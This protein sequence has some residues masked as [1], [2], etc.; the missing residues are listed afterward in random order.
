MCKKKG[1]EAQPR[2]PFFILCRGFYGY[3]DHHRFP[4]GRMVDIKRVIRLVLWFVVGLVIGGGCTLARAENTPVYQVGY[5]APP[6]RGSAPLGVTAMEAC[7]ACVTR[8]WSAGYL[9]SLTVVGSSCQIL[10]GGSPVSACTVGPV[11]RCPAGGSLAAGGNYTN[12]SAETCI[13]VTPCVAPQTRNST[14]GVCEAPPIPSCPAAGTTTPGVTGG[15]YTGLGSMPATLCISGCT[16]STQG[17][18]VGT[19]TGWGLEAGKST[20]AT[21]TNAPPSTVPPE[22]PKAKCIIAGQGFG[23]VNGQVVCVP[24]T[25][26]TAPKT[27]TKTSPGGNSTIDQ[28]TTTICTGAGSCTTTTTTTTTSGGSGP[29]GTGPGST[30]SEP[31]TTETDQPKS[32]FC[33]ENPNSSMCKNSSF[34]GAC[35]SLP[36][37]DGDA[38][39]CAQAKASFETKCLLEKEPEGAA[40]TL[41]KS[42]AEGGSDSVISPL[43]ASQVET[44]DIAS[45]ISDAA[46][47]RTL[48]ASCIS[49]QS[50]TIGL[51]SYSIDTVL[52]CS[53]AQ[54]MGY[55]FV[56][57]ASVHAVKI[58]AGGSV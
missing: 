19:S 49:S 29:G 45:I 4:G 24:P 21:C 51:G 22:D 26:T 40:Y 2:H 1:A 58:L 43:H 50:F 30:T 7:T 5:G 11:Y 23:T 37:C 20:G 13:N 41:G 12:N 34:A 33:E 39:Q 6:I 42:I 56:A 3:L 32:V 8:D 10:L 27:T 25:K 38:V 46:G 14:T 28:T 47:Q 44:R 54:I 52:F 15:F 48:S 9:A 31:T 16:Y 35:G 55:L 36:A 18:G 53:F 17:L 57:V